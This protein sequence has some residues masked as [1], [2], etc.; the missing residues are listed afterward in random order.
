LG[1]LAANARAESTVGRALL[2]RQSGK[3]AS[4]QRHAIAASTVPPD[5]ASPRNR[6]KHHPRKTREDVLSA[7][8]ARRT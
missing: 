1:G 3:A 8:A 6:G 5:A 7:G 4:D 2:R